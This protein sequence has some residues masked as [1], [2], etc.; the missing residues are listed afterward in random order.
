MSLK[1]PKTIS[2]TDALKMLSE[3]N[4]KC[5]TGCRNYAMLMMMYRAGLRVSEVAKLA[6]SDVNFETKL[7][8]VQ[9]SKGKKDKKKDRYIP[10][11][12][13]VIKA[14]LE[15]LKFRPESNYFFCTMKGGI[16]DTHYIREVCYR[17]SE[18]AGV[19]IQDGTEK[20]KVSP[21]KLRHSFATD[22]LRSG[23]FNIREIQDLLGHANLATTMIYTHVAIDELQS[24][25]ANRK[26]LG[27]V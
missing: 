20:K 17:M 1:L 16:I 7:I 8:Y 10:M 24:K 3:I 15:W 23:D 26:G 9:Q 12:T 14:C 21:H 6:L 25:F 22:I 4:T 27:T 5:P 2:Q 18:R 11:D 13:D 19:F